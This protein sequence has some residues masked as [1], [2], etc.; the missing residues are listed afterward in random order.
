M[1]DQELN[2]DDL[3]EEFTRS[4]EGY[5]PATPRKTLGAPRGVEDSSGETRVSHILTLVAAVV[6]HPFGRSRTSGISR[7]IDNFARS[8]ITSKLED[9]YVELKA[10]EGRRQAAALFLLAA[11]V[12]RGV[13]LA[14]EL[15]KNF[16]F[17]LPVL[18]KEAKRR[19]CRSTRRAFVEFAVSFLEAGNPRLLRWIL[20]QKDMYSG[21]L[22]GLGSDDEETVVYVL[23]P[24]LRSVLFGSATLE[25]LSYISGN[26]DGGH[27]SDVAHEVLLVVCTDPCNGLMPYG[28]LKGNVK[29]LS[30][31]MKKLKATESM[32]HKELLL[33]IVKGRP[34]LCSSYMDEFPYHL[35]P[36]AS[37]QWLVHLITDLIS[38][39][40]FCSSFSFLEASKTSDPPCLET[41]EVQCILKCILPCSCTRSVINK[42]LL[43]SDILVKHGSIRLLLE[44]L[45]LLDSL[46]SSI[47][48]LLD[49]MHPKH[50]PEVTG[51][52]DLRCLR[53]FLCF[54][55]ADK[56]NIGENDCRSSSGDAYLQKWVTFR[57]QIQDEVRSVLPDAQVL[58]KLLTSF[59]NETSGISSFTLKRCLNSSNAT[60]KKS[61]SD[62]CKAVAE[63]DI[64]VSAID[65]VDMAEDY[66][67]VIDVD[68]ADTEK[69]AILA[70]AEIWGPN[71]DVNVS[72][73][74]NIMSLFHAKLLDVLKLYLRTLP[75]TLEGSFDFMKIISNNPSKLSINLQESVLSLLL[76]YTGQAREGKTSVRMPPMMYKSLHPLI[77]LLIFSPVQKIR[78]KVFT[79]AKTAMIS[80]G[81]F[82]HNLSEIEAWFLFL[83]GFYKDNC[84]EEFHGVVKL[85]DLSTVVISFL[86]DA[87][88]TVANNLYKYL[89]QLR[90]FI[91]QLNGQEDICPDF[92]PL[93]ICILQKCIRVL[94]SDSRTFNLS[95]RSMIS[96]YVHNTLSFILQTQVYFFSQLLGHDNCRKSL[97][98]WRPLN[99]LLLL[100][101]G[102][103]QQQVCYPSVS[104][105]GK[106]A[107]GSRGSFYSVLSKVSEF[108][109]NDDR[110]GLFAAA[111]AMCFSVVCANP[112][113]I[114][115]NLPML[116][117]TV[118]HL[119][120]EHI[121]FLSFVLF[122]CEFLGNAAHG[123][124]EMFLSSMDRVQSLVSNNL[125]EI[126]ADE[127]CRASGVLDK[128]RV[129]CLSDVDSME[130]LAVGF[131]LLVEH[132]PFYTLFSGIMK[133]CSCSLLKSTNVRDV[134]RARLGVFVGDWTLPLRFVLFWA[135]QI[136]LWYRT[137]PSSDLEQ[138]FELCLYFANHILD[139]ILF[140]SSHTHALKFGDT[141]V[142]ADYVSKA[143]DLI[144]HHPVVTLSILHPLCDNR[145]TEEDLLDGLKAGLELSNKHVHPMDDQILHLL[146]RQGELQVSG[147]SGN[148]SNSVS[149]LHATLYQSVIKASIQLV[150]Q[151]VL[152]I[153]EKIDLFIMAKDFGSLFPTI[154]IFHALMQFI[155]PF[156]LMEI[157]HWML[158][159]IEDNIGYWVSA[160]ASTLSVFFDVT[161]V[162]LEI[163][164]N[165]LKDTTGTMSSFLWETRSRISSD[166]I[167]QNVYSKILEFAICFR[168]GS[169]DLCLLK[170]VNAIYSQK[171]QKSTWST[172]LLP[173]VM[174]FC[175][176]VMSSPMKLIIHC[177]YETNKMKA[178]I[179]FQLTEASPLHRSLFGMAFLRLIKGLPSVDISST[180]GVWPPKFEMIS[181]NYSPEF[182]N[183]DLLLLLPAALSYLTS[184]YCKS[185]NQGLK[186]FGSIPS[187]YSR[188]LLKGFGDW[189][190]YTSGKIFHEDFSK[191]KPTS[192][193]QFRSCFSRTL[194]G[195][196]VHMLHF[197]FISSVGSMKR[198]HRLDTFNSL[199]DCGAPNDQLL[200]FNV[201]EI[202]P[203]SSEDSFNIINRAMAKISFAQFQ[204][205]FLNILVHSLNNL[206]RRFP[207][208]LEHSNDTDITYM[209]RFLEVHILGII[210]Q[211]SIDMKSFL[212]Q[213]T[214]LLHRFDDPATLRA[215]RIILCK[216]EARPSALDILELLL[217]HSE[218]VNTILWNDHDVDSP[219]SINI[220]TLL[221]PVPSIFKLLD[222]VSPLKA[223]IAGQ[224]VDDA[225]SG[226]GGKNTVLLFFLKDP[227]ENVGVNSSELLSLLLSGYGATLSEVDVHAL[228]FMH[229]IESAKGP[230]S[231]NIADMDYLWG[232]SAIKIRREKNF[233][234]LLSSNNIADLETEDE[235]RQRLFRENIPLDSKRC[236]MT[237]LHFSYNR[238][239]LTEPMTY[240][241][242]NLLQMP[243]SSVSETQPY[244]PGFILP[245]S[246]HCLRRGYVVPM[247]FVR[248][249][250]L[251]VVL[252]SI[253]STD[254][255]V[256][257][258]GYEALGT[259][260]AILEEY[261]KIPSLTAIFSAEASFILLDP[262]HNSFQV[263]SKFLMHS[264]R[265]D[266]KDV[267]LFQSSVASNSIHFKANFLWILKL[268]YLGVNFDDDARVFTRK[269]LFELLLSFYVSSLSD[270]ETK[271]L[272]LQ[273][274]KKSVKLHMLANMLVKHHGLISWL[275]SVISFNAKRLQGDQKE[276]SMNQMVTALEVVNSLV[277][278][279][280]ICEWLRDDALEQ[281]S[282]L[283]QLLHSMFVGSSKLLKD[284]V[285]LI[286]PILAVIISTLKISQERKIFQ[287]HFHLSIEALFQLCRTIDSEVKDT[288]SCSTVCLGLTTILMSTPPPV[289][290][291]MDKAKLLNVVMWAVS[292]LQSYPIQK[293][294]PNVARSSEEA[295][296][297]EPVLS[298][299]LR[300]ITG[301]IILGNI[302]GKN[303]G[304][305]IPSLPL[306]EV[307]G[308][309]PQVLLGKVT[310]LEIESHD[311]HSSNTLAA[312]ILHLQ[313][314]LGTECVA[315]SSVVSALSLLLFDTCNPTETK[316][317]D[318]DLKSIIA[319]LCGKMSCPIEAS[320]AWRWSFDRPWRD[321]STERS[322]LQGMEE[323]HS[324]QT[325]L[326]LFS[327][328]LGAEP[329]SPFSC[330][331]MWKILACSRGKR[332]Y[333]SGM[334]KNAHNRKQGFRRR[335]SQPHHVFS[336]L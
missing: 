58:L 330:M 301:S 57:G 83:P 235:Q 304:E 259:F 86:C 230:C 56:C 326:L 12:R 154:H 237:A 295:Q 246:I 62:P 44:A 38:A 278:L 180:D 176:I 150:E 311:C 35:E 91:S 101:M 289:R 194:L 297:E 197:Y 131:S 181:V 65:S 1:E 217:G 67:R 78:S 163:L 43:H 322:H 243:S 255:D 280:P 327:N 45:K 109:K 308:E 169:A 250:L 260:K 42:G 195:K 269:H 27:A 276:F 144:V 329:G 331:R 11:I 114:L 310:W 253:S 95:E 31:L 120:R 87:V 231:H 252:V 199:F 121:Q 141:P 162:A 284:N 88:S 210:V 299:L 192:V 261:Q 190:R 29:R 325:L 70:L 146:K 292:A 240:F 85:K 283:S 290:S 282:K 90:V 34:L 77:S 187:F 54:S 256:R 303:N 332:A 161:N 26:P 213:L 52:T 319:S 73:T 71:L 14:S 265:V 156:K 272:I 79:L 106:V 24:G 113:E 7:N 238:A 75:L 306:E 23:P 288:I 287:P 93:V 124:D 335:E 168:L 119:P 138:M 64:V 137:R 302:S 294:D 165:L 125:Q 208:N 277:S 236:M 324:F 5:A 53:D 132:A 201:N 126:D 116:L 184:V 273:I 129:M 215:M 174:Q 171:Y 135:Y 209:F 172:A 207:W 123:W 33:A 104:L 315:S 100:A 17:D 312:I 167:L 309:S 110:D 323:E 115:E 112:D 99:D 61:K 63:V 151:L 134:L 149:N 89:E 286:D 204:T 220:G 164:C 296:M 84:S 82:D 30:D 225:S 293:S 318:E 239:E 226:L 68:A 188:I 152:L 103:Y 159:K 228:Y 66:E 313:Y 248:L 175:R 28:N 92:S 245:F 254:E 191:C 105:I 55:E 60:R 2:E 203:L 170:V 185:R 9:L 157:V 298:K 111:T 279:R 160:K 198:R 6:A 21:V 200:D 142:D 148:G 193:E 242:M 271:A 328:A 232:R 291:Q 182:S 333:F 249:G 262:S 178:K 214:S 275:Y 314:L 133:S 81:A 221:Q 233:D 222:F 46:N 40:N 47:D 48:G 97:C 4:G 234:K 334:T 177:I 173:S 281:L 117:A 15:A 155:S 145:S 227:Q 128:H 158:C 247:E 118:H 130:C 72:K 37:P 219:A 19:T 22:R 229:E 241:L 211:L 18:T 98:E 285:S 244:D 25:Q 251:A 32:K 108:L 196:A 270:S 206:V 36:R 264:P 140:R 263:I 80:T 317:K 223:A 76:E 216:L 258:L 316:Y 49:S 127:N 94:E 59:T 307:S 8:I 189:Q 336:P 212:I 179:L 50:S 143:A 257:K 266:F 305:H 166:F 218:F 139:K 202:D 96:L 102:I 153:K 69:Q 10:E 268:L 186:L 20:Q 107:K 51:E 274:V 320:P 3:L 224:L 39:V 147:V 41:T 74:E 321:F 13:I 16:R 205:K 136:R 122:Q 267:P 183:D 300:W